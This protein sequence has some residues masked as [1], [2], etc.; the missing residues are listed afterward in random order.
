MLTTTLSATEHHG[1]SNVN[2]LSSALPAGAATEATLRMVAAS[3]KLPPA[4]GPQQ[5][6]GSLSIV[7]AAGTVLPVHH[8]PALVY[9][10]L[11]LGGAGAVVKAHAG[12]L[13]SIS[14]QNLNLGIDAY[15]KLYNKSSVPS[16]ADI[17]IMTLVLLA[18][19]GKRLD[20]TSPVAFSAGLGIRASTAAA[21]GDAGPVT[22][23]SLIVEALTYA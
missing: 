13:R 23:G 15:V 5:T 19:S 6:V 3:L 9:R 8:A 4:L 16:A 14:V 1:C 10:N 21:D 12:E 2:V 20:F 18:G 11:N 17:P 22:S 7:P